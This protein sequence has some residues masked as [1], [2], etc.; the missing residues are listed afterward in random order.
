MADL[1]IGGFIGHIGCGEWAPPQRLTEAMRRSTYWN[2][3]EGTYWALQTY[4]TE[5]EAIGELLSS[6]PDGEIET[7]RKMLAGFSRMEARYRG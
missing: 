6:I 2:A 7:F 5:R 3:E 1:W 4:E